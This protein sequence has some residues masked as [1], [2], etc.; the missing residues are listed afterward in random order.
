FEEPF[1]IGHHVSRLRGKIHAFCPRTEHKFGGRAGQ[2]IAALRLT[3]FHC[4]D[5]NI[6][7][8]NDPQTLPQEINTAFMP[9]VNIP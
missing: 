8:I 7:V 9:D 2:R 3:R 5:I 6:R 1:R 4:P